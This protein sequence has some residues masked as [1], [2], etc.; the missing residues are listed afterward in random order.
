MI[1]FSSSAGFKLRFVCLDFELYEPLLNPFK[2]SNQKLCFYL[3]YTL[4]IECNNINS[5][6]GT[7]EIYRFEGDLNVSEARAHTRLIGKK[8]IINFYEC[9]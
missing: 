4:V 2:L 5:I 1:S 9:V 8:T 7:K 3:Y 6:D